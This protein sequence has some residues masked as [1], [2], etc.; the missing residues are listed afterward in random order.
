MKFTNVV[1][2]CLSSVRVS[3]D[4]RLLE[5]ENLREKGFVV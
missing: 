3:V 5:R 1:L 4:S 2:R